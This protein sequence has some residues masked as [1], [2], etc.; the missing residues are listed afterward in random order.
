MTQILPYNPKLKKL[1]QRLRRN[2]T[3]GEIRL[4]KYLRSKQMVRYRFIRQKPI[5]EYIVD[6]FCPE[7]LLAIEIDGSSHDEKRFEKDTNRQE[8]LESLGVT[9]IRF[10]EKEVLMNIEDVLFSIEAWVLQNT[11]RP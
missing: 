9:V 5:N 7:L 8:A 6:F 1:A 10:N 4:W 3:Y 11:P 2:M